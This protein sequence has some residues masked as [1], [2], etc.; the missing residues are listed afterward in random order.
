QEIFWKML[1]KMLRDAGD[2]NDKEMN[3]SS[4]ERN[5][6]VEQMKEMVCNKQVA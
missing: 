6:C 5:Y 2:N 3:L 4:I 1:K